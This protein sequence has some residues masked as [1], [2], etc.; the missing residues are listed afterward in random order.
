M[1]RQVNEDH[2]MYYNKG[3]ATDLQ[4]RQRHP[5]DRKLKDSQANV[6]LM[7]GTWAKPCFSEVNTARRGDSAEFHQSQEVRCSRP[8]WIC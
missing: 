1:S 4:L 8:W 6:C 3:L 2:E 5:N 7:E